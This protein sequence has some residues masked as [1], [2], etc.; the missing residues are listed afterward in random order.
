MRTP[1]DWSSEL[2]TSLTWVVSVFLVALVATSLIGSLL[3]RS[4]VWGRQFRRLTAGYFRPGRTL[5]SWVPLLLALSILFL[6]VLGVRLSV[7]ISYVSNGVFTSLQRGDVGAF[8][9]VIGIF[10]LILVITIAHQLLNVYIVGVLN[11]RWRAWT[12]EL[13]LDDYMS[14]G[15]YHRVGFTK[16]GVDN[17]DQRIQEDVA[18]FVTTSL[19]LVNGTIDAML[20]LLSFTFVLWQLSAT[21]SVLGLE[22]PRAMLIIAYAYA[23]IATVIAFRI[24]RPLIRLN[25][26]DQMLTGSFRYALVRLRDASEHVVLYRGERTERDTLDTR[27]AAIVANAWS[28]LHRGL[29]F[30]GVNFVFTQASVIIPYLIQ[31]PRVLSGQISIGDVTQTTTAFGQVHGSLSFFRNAYDDFA[32][33]RAVLIRLT[34]LLDTDD[35]SRAMSRPELVEDDGLAIRGLT[36]RTPDAQVLVNELDLQL[37]AGDSLLIKGPSGSGK[38]TLLRSVAGLWPYTD[39][40]VCRPL[41]SRSLFVSQQ[42]YLPL[43]SLRT[44]LAYPAQPDA[45]DDDRAREVL[46]KVQLAHLV[47]RLDDEDV[48]WSRQ[49]SPGE[50]QRLGFVRVLVGQPQVVFLDEATSAV[51]EG[52]ECMLYELIRTELP[53]TIVVSVSHRSTLSGFHAREL[54]LLGAGRWSVS[55]LSLVQR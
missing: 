31:G 40:T 51:D 19:I 47:E 25:F 6:T 1:V 26:L 37:T 14:G 3:L 8:W 23:I 38:T 46:R 11:I 34:G 45:V 4:T 44:A 2:A 10:S 36:V 39:G 22:I 55:E 16:N 53:D 18:A 21:L 49:L 35:E 5:Q 20:S 41:D 42:P 28:L 32:R 43:G 52:L 27:F 13:V 30:S 24:G 9:S 33:Y 54:E 17:P 29:K 15:A 48:D 12:N 50:Q 7:L